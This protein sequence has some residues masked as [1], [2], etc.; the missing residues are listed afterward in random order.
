MSLC[1]NS[2]H[3]DTSHVGTRGWSSTYEFWGTHNSVHNIGCCLKTFSV[4]LIKPWKC[5]REGLQ[6]GCLQHRGKCKRIAK[7][8]EKYWF[9]TLWWRRKHNLWRNS[10]TLKLYAV[11]CHFFFLW[12]RWNEIFTISSICPDYL[13]IPLSIKSTPLMYSVI[14][15]IGYGDH[16]CHIS[17][18]G[19]ANGRPS[20]ETRR[21][22]EKIKDLFPISNSCQNCSNNRGQL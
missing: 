11:A 19:S 13:L 4:H 3:K 9:T 12:D 18:V 14:L 21:W 22:E 6:D 17:L 5:Q 8:S 16:R 2:S 7:H 20:R 15:E 1:P 10:K